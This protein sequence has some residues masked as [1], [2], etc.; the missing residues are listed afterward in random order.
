MAVSDMKHIWDITS[1]VQSLLGYRA[2]KYQ[3]AGI[4]VIAGVDVLL[5]DVATFS[6]DRLERVPGWCLRAGS[7]GDGPQLM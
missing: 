3:I 7:M 2:P 5:P 4:I 6:G 1:T